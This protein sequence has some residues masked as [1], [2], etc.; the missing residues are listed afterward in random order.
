MGTSLVAKV[1]REVGLST[2]NRIQNLTISA[3]SAH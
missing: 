1:N 2:A 3:I